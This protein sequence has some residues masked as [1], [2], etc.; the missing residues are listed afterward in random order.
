[1]REKEKKDAVKEEERQRERRKRRGEEML[2]MDDEDRE[3][4][5]ITKNR[6]AREII[7]NIETVKRIA[8]KRSGGDVVV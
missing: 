1:M 4:K 3:G 7:S 5:D 6:E 2:V 8:G